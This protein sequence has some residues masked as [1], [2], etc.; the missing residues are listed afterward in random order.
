MAVG[1]TAGSGS[2]IALS[3]NC[4]FT[5]WASALA[6]FEFQCVPGWVTSLFRTHSLPSHWNALPVRP[7]SSTWWT[8]DSSLATQVKCPVPSLKYLW[9]VA[10]FSNPTLLVELEFPWVLMVP[11]TGFFPD[12]NS[13]LLF[14]FLDSSL[15]DKPQK[16][17]AVSYLSL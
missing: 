9:T 7:F 17:D 3:T 2:D 15:C 11:S 10:S 4:P 13:K 6:W 14:S 1:R 8:S 16:S 12:I 5:P